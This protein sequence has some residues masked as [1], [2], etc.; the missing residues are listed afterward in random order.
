MAEEQQK[1]PEQEGEKQ[2]GK[3]KLLIFSL[4]G[5]LLISATGGGIA[6]YYFKIKKESQL[7]G[8]ETQK[9]PPMPAEL[10]Q[11]EQ[12][13][14][15]VNLGSF[16]VN[17]AD[18]DVQRYLKVSITL[19]VVNQQVQREVNNYMPAIKDAIIDLISSKYYKDI[20]TP[21]GRERLKIELLK[22]INAILPDGGV[23]AI[24]FTSF[25]VQAM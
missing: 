9:P 17:L 23:K 24:Y 1:Q 13:G 18:T 11:A 5:L 7:G 3:K 15:F 19:E 4:L 21:E 16:I 20:R 14:I 8:N 6:Y 2:T 12:P 25:V 10:K 22:R